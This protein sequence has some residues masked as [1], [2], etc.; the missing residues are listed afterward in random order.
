MPC[1]AE[2]GHHVF[3]NKGQKSRRAFGGGGSDPERKKWRP[4]S[5]SKYAR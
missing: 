3:L 1:T 4:S 5:S 2:D